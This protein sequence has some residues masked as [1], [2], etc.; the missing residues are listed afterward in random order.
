MLYSLL[1]PTLHLLPPEVAH[2][3]AINALKRGIAGHVA[4]VKSPVLE[5][6]AF[7]LTFPNPV[8]L[9]AGFDKNAEAI[10]GLQSQGFGFIEIGTV[11]KLPQEGNPKPRIFRLSEDKAIINRL[12]FNNGGIDTFTANLADRDRARGI[13]GANIGKNRDSKDTIGDYTSLLEAVYPLA[14]YV[15]INVSSPNTA[16]LRDL[17]QK[18]H[19]HGLLAAIMETRR[20]LAADHHRN[21]PLLLKISPDIDDVVKEEVAEVS[22]NHGIDGMIIGNTTI[23]RPTTLKSLQRSEAGGLSGT[24]LF[25]LSTQVL[26]DMYRLTQG[27]IPLIGVGGIAS[28]ADAYA[29]IRAGASM[30]QLYTALTYQGFGLVKKINQR[31]IEL[32]ERDDFSHISEAVGLDVK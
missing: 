29:K 21:V 2:H 16:G 30:I 32:L 9:A 13:V 25:A 17:Q 6:N 26:S 27:R 8:G 1:R 10:S 28:G 23:R 12:G 3:L 7:G 14:D 15:T 24:P 19:L 18:K 22:L 4:A 20:T 31:L 5:V 11:T